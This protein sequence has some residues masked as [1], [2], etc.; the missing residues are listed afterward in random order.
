MRPLAPL[1]PSLPLAAVRARRAPPPP[2][3]RVVAGAAVD[4]VGLLGCRSGC[5]RRPS[6][7]GSRS[8]RAGRGRRRGRSVFAQRDPDAAVPSAPPT[9]VAKEAMSPLAGAAVHAVVAVVAVDEVEV[10]GAA[11]ERCRCRG[12]RPPRRSAPGPPRTCRRRGR[13]S[14]RSS[15]PAPPSTMS[16]PRPPWI[17]SAPGAAADQVVAEAAEDHVVARRRPRS[18]RGPASRAACRARRCRRSSP[19]RPW[20]R[21]IFAFG[22]L[23]A[24]FG[25]GC[26]PRGEHRRG[27]RAA[28]RCCPDAFPHRL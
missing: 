16:L 22:C 8:G 28:D 17:R 11:V 5:R 18:R 1:Q 24:A 9:S 15:S 20:Q 10:A 12:C 25:G 13:R 4:H 27:K 2:T 6:L 21:G 14:T 7:R 3:D 23:R 19:A 26:H